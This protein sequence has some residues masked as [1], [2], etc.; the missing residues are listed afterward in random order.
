MLRWTRAS[1]AQAPR[2]RSLNILHSATPPF[3]PHSTYEWFRVMTVLVNLFTVNNV[4][5]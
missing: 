1:C 5:G 4:R 2:K 3:I